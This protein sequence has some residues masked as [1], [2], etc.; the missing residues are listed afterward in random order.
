[1]CV[2][3]TVVLC[4][5]KHSEFCKAD[6]WCALLQSCLLG[7]KTPNKPSKIELK[8]KKPSCSLWETDSADNCF[9][10]CRCIQ[11]QE[12]TKSHCG[13]VEAHKFGAGPRGTIG[14]LALCSCWPW[15]TKG[16]GTEK[17]VKL[18]MKLSVKNVSFLCYEATFPL[19]LTANKYYGSSNFWR[20]FVDQ[21][22]LDEKLI[23]LLNPYCP[24]ITN[25][26]NPVMAQQ[27]AILIAVFAGI[28][29]C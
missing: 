7:S 21:W 11:K 4:T 18:L 28:L 20:W 23:K 15:Q 12:N 19:F 6:E 16:N 2:F 8:W 9:L 17:W 29:M 13:T 14:S 3:W 24:I 1:M 26:T 25:F 22:V 27:S 10:N 5:C